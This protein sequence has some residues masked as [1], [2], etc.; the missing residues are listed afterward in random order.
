MISKRSK[1][2]RWILVSVES[3]F[4]CGFSFL[5]FGIFDWALFG[6]PQIPASMGSE[7]IGL[8]FIPYLAM[9]ID[10]LSDLWFG[11]V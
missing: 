3:G 7:G 1:W 11:I 5:R 4:V 8:I 10:E 2:H 6:S 9:S